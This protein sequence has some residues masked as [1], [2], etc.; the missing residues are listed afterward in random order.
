MLTSWNDVIDDL[1]SW[2]EVEGYLQQGWSEARDV[3]TGLVL[4]CDGHTLLVI[5]P[6]AGKAAER[7]ALHRAGFRRSPGSD[8]AWWWTAPE[9]ASDDRR[10]D[11]PASLSGRMRHAFVLMQQDAIRRRDL[12]EMA[13]RVLRDIYQSAPGSLMLLVAADEEEGWG[14]EDDEDDEAWLPGLDCAT[15]E[16]AVRARTHRR[17]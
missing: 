7:R 17:A 9:P 1:R 11:V 2:E 6:R 5:E 12:A 15:L 13:V 3:A 8:G 10:L 4:E 16:A 14:D